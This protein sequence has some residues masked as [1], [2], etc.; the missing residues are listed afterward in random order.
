VVG[1]FFLTQMRLAAAGTEVLAVLVAL[2]LI[3]ALLGYLGDRALPPG[4]HGSRPS[5]SWA[6]S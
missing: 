6:R 2:T 4:S 5:T 3:P 1:V